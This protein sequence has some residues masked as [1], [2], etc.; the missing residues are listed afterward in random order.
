M[1]TPIGDS[2]TCASGGRIA[3]GSFSGP[4]IIGSVWTPNRDVAGNVI[5]GNWLGLPLNTWLDVAGQSVNNVVQV[6]HLLNLW[7]T[8]SASSIAGA[9]G[10]AAWDYVNQRMYVIGGGHGDGSSCEMGIYMLDAAK[11]Q[12]TRVRDRDPI[13]QAAGWSDAAGSL[14]AGEQ[15][16]GGNAPLLN[17]N[18]GSMHTYWGVVWIPPE[19]MG[20][21]NGGMFYPGLAKAV[22]NFDTHVWT[23]THWFTPLHVGS[24][25]WSNCA[26]FVD[27]TSVYG[28]HGNW[29]H[30]QFDLTQTEATD[31]SATS[32]G[33]LYTMRASADK[34]SNAGSAAWG[35][36]RERRETFS[37][38][39][40]GSRVRVRYGAALDANATDWAAYSDNITLTS[41][42]GSHTDFNGTTLADSAN[43]CAAGSGYDHATQTLHL[44]GNTVGGQLYKI[45]GLSTNTWNVEK[46]AGTGAL[47]TAPQGA[48]GRVRM[49]TFAGKK[50]LLRVSGTTHPL[51]VMRIS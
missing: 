32:F 10:G 24:M 45:T 15:W 50:F 33:K 37:F 27:G 23:T 36:L 16:Y 41:S 46:V 51:Q 14:Q 17:G 20:N 40:G 29:Y 28:P 9:W 43:L 18:P 3:A 2:Y 22:W 26:A 4:N 21:T 7:G 1:A 48:Y 11:L 19:V 34:Q 8:D 30:W 13:E 5:S 31:A 35:L 42:D 6:P 12:F 47:R 44:M 25:D 49:A 38:S 39:A